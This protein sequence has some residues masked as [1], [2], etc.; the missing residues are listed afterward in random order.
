MRRTAQRSPKA[1]TTTAAQATKPDTRRDTEPDTSMG[2]GRRRNPTVPGGRQPPAT[3]TDQS[4]RPAIR[5]LPGVVSCTA[6][7]RSSAPNTSP[8]QPLRR[9]REPRRTAHRPL[10]LGTPPLL[11]PVPPRINPRP[12]LRRRLSGHRG[13]LL[14][15]RKPRRTRKPDRRL[16]V[17]GRAHRTDQPAAV[18]QL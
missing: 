2:G 18:V 4:S 7:A 5:P 1:G 13:R 15:L 12:N 6:S 17:P 11:V 14:R 8:D 16:P 3:P 9:R 10:P